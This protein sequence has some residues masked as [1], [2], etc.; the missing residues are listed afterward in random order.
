M[1]RLR[2]LC[3]DLGFIDVR[4]YIASGNVVFSSPLSAAALRNGLEQAIEAEFG[5]S[6][7]VVVLTA[8]Q[9]AAVMKR[10]PFPDAQP[11]ALHVAFATA[12]IGKADVERLSA[13]DF[14]PE[15]VHVRGSVVYLHMPTGYGRSGL[16]AE[17]TKVKLPTTV[18]N[19]RTITALNEMAAAP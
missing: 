18:R 15:E 7:V 11:G 19:W 5:F 1:T 4:T 17:V 2:E 6:V 13:I 3:E 14:E 16:A 12:P 10:N 9:V 8:Q